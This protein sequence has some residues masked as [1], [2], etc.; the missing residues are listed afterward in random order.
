MVL[1]EK[2]LNLPEQWYTMIKI[3][4]REKFPEY[5]EEYPLNFSEVIQGTAES[6]IMIG[7]LEYWIRKTKK[8]NDCEIYPIRQ[9]CKFLKLFNI[10]AF[11]ERFFKHVKTEMKQGIELKLDL[12]CIYE[13]HKQLTNHLTVQ[14]K[15]KLCKTP[16]ME[17]D[18]GFV[19]FIDR[20]CARYGGSFDYTVIMFY[21]QGRALFQS[22]RHHEVINNLFEL[23]E[24]K[25][26]ITDCDAGL[27]GIYATLRRYDVSF[28]KEDV[29]LHTP[30]KDKIKCPF[31]ENWFCEVIES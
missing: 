13:T 19:N 9:R 23:Y 17:F 6:G 12:T 10:L 31:R 20:Y 14:F 11:E 24:S 15:E 25:N 16:P 30:G 27:K 1:I 26:H 3:K 28:D 7:C 8:Y 29:Y 2:T 4:D 18:E 5:T 21:Q 22:R